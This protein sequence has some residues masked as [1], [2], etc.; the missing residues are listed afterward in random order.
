MLTLSI[1]RDDILNGTTIKDKIC[2]FDECKHKIYNWQMNAHKIGFTNGCF[3]ILHPGHVIYLEKVKS[4]VDNLI[5]GLNSDQSVVHIKGKDRPI[6]SEEYRAITLAG[7]QSV[8]YVVLFDEDTPLELIK[9]IRPDLLAK[10]GD[11]LESEIIGAKEVKQWGGKIEIVPL[12]EQ[13]STTRLI[14]AIVESEN[15]IGRK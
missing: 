6:F 9:A 4:K 1:Q 14:N 11:Y 7:L 8:D 15:V 10:G 13:L 3:D 2:S 5:V 12:V